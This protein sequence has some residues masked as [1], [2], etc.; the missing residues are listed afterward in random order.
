MLLIALAIIVNPPRD[1]NLWVGPR[2]DAWIAMACTQLSEKEW[3]ENFHM[4]KGTV[5]Y[6]VNEVED[7]VK[8][9]D[10]KLR[11][12]VPTFQRVALTIY[13][14]ASTAEYRS[15]ANLF[16]VSRSFVS[17]CVKEVS[18][19]IV[20]RLKSRYITIPK[21]DD[22]KQVIATYKGKWGFP[23]C[24]GAI[25]G[26]HVPI[27]IPSENHTDYVNRK[28]YYSII[29]Q[30]LV[31]SRYLFRDIVVGWPGSV[32]DARVLSNSEVYKLGNDGALFPDIKE[33]ILGQDIHPCILGD[34]AYPLL[35]W[36]LKPFPENQ[37]TP[38]KHRRFNYRL[39]RPRMTVEDT[40]GRWKGRF[41]R[42]AKRIDMKVEGV[43]HLV[44]ASCILHN[45]SE[46]RR[47]PILNEWFEQ[48]QDS[49]YPQPDDRD[50][51]LR[52]TNRERIDAADTRNILA[53][54]FMTEEGRDIGSG[55]DGD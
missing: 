30:G 19:A 41:P 24:A 21:G 43:V 16:G 46:L 33:T 26:T 9:T 23:M 34:P 1:R 38:T 51:L 50:V 28:S 20:K 22:L 54:F 27:K 42:F 5:L 32:H 44:A 29:M 17:I 14:M 11:K 13:F 37:N 48:A 39:S 15:V 2:T 49:D 18:Q 36:L 4:S 10:S 25:D 31:D 12:A 53:D 45:I 55:A 6:I 52:M 7:D 47:D 3:Y 40:F 35:P 8:H